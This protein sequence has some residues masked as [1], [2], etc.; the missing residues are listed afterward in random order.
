[1][2]KKTLPVVEM[3]ENDIVFFEEMFSR[4]PPVTRNHRMRS[5]LFKFVSEFAESISID[6]EMKAWLIH[7]ADDD[8]VVY[9]YDKGWLYDDGYRYTAGVARLMDL[10]DLLP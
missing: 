2:G 9:R 3:T 8:F 6:K 5:R 1:M 10:P 7:L 4:N